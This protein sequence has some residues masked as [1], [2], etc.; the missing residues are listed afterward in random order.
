MGQYW[1]GCGDFFEKDNSHH[2][3]FFNFSSPISF[4]KFI[5]NKHCCFK[6]QKSKLFF[7]KLKNNPKNGSKLS[8]MTQNDIFIKNRISQKISLKKLNKGS[9]LRNFIF[10]I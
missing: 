9:V 10:C 8:K 2:F 1:V 3:N 6:L 5:E 7:H 4:F